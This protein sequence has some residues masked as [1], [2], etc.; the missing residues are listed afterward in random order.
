MRATARR[1]QASE[2]CFVANA[3]GTW[4]IV[5]YDNGNDTAGS[6]SLSFM[7]VTGGPLENGS[8]TDFLGTAVIGRQFFLQDTGYFFGSN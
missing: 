1:A 5:I 2:T 3:T 4:I 7:N 6:Y 8:D